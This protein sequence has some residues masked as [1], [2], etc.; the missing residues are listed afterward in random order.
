MYLK[1]ESDSGPQTKARLH[2]EPTGMRSQHNDSLLKATGRRIKF[3]QHA[4]IS[5]LQLNIF[6]MIPIHLDIL[7]LSLC[8]ALHHPILSAF[9]FRPL[10]FGRYRLYSR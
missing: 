5:F 6:Y 4:E 2:T 3:H 8:S 10:D 1:L 7:S 9:T